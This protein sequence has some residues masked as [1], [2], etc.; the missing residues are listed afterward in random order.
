MKRP[1]KSQ[2]RMIRMTPDDWRAVNAVAE[3]YGL[4]TAQLLR[5]AIH[6]LVRDEKLV[7]EVVLEESEVQR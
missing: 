1:P 7:K 4:R 3:K 5:K 6:R 2:P